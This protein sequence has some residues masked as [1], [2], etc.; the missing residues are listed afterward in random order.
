[1]LHTLVT[2]IAP[3][4]RGFTDLSGLSCSLIRLRPRPFAA[5]RSLVGF[6]VGAPRVTFSLIWDP[7][8]S[9]GRQVGGWVRSQ[10]PKWGTV[11]ARVPR[12]AE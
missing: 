12:S 8:G 3:R 5:I 2:K 4:W 9:P 1:M 10:R 6:G 7:L 11:K